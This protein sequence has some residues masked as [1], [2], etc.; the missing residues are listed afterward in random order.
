MFFVFKQM[1]AYEMRISDWSSDVCSSDLGENVVIL[2]MTDIT[3]TNAATLVTAQNLRE[4]GF[5]IELQAMDWSTVTSRRAVK[6]PLDKGGW[7]IFT[8]W[9]IRGAIAHPGTTPSTDAGCGNGWVGHSRGSGG[10]REG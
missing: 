8:T 6:E 1:T 3:V 7:S 10:E 5:N 2:H 9:W 4:V